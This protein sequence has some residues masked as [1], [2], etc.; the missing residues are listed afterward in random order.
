[1]RMNQETRPRLTQSNLVHRPGLGKTRYLALQG[2][3]ELQTRET[4]PVSLHRCWTLVVGLPGPLL[5]HLLEQR[6]A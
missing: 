6:H 3:Q 4:S 2:S 5:P 1:M